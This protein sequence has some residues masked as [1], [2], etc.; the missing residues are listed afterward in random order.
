[1]KESSPVL[2][3]FLITMLGDLYDTRGIK[4]I[5]A[6]L[7]AIVHAD[8]DRAHNMDE[9]DESRRLALLATAIEEIVC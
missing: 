5:L 7:A 1:M 4:A 6:V 2:D 8:S 9:P 3:A